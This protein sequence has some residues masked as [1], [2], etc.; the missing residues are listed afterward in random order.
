MDQQPIR[1]LIFDFGGV[2]CNIDISLTE[3]A[4]RELGMQS[5]DHSYSVTERENF[6]A[7]FE[8]GLLTPRQFRDTLRP[9]FAKPVSDEAIDRAWNALLLDIPASR[10]ALLKQLRN[11]YRLFLLS[12]TNRIHYDHYLAKLQDV[13][14]IAG[15]GDLFDKAYFSHAIGLRK[16]FPEVFR[17]VTGDAGILPE[18]TLFID[19]SPQHVEG[20]RKAGL[21]AYHLL[22]GE[23][24]TSLFNPEMQ[25]LRS[26]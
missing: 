13:H 3:A 10:V 9:L 4:F 7:S 19:D 26:W 24:I 6:F 14:G 11:R 2:I 1:N 15:F 20:A 25:F 23:E 18:E 16:P 12:N 21:K 17:Y 22:P 5:F 8:T